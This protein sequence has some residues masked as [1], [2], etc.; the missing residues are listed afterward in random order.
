MADTVKDYLARFTAHLEARDLENAVA[1]AL[2]LLSE[3][4]RDVPELYEGILAP[5]LNRIEVPRAQE[6]A[7][8]WQEHIQ[9]AIVQAVM[10]ASW[11]YVLSQR[12]HSGKPG[13]G[14]RVM[15]AC[16]EEE[17]HEIGIR[18]GADFFRILGFDTAYIG[19]NTPRG[20]LLHAAGTIQP[21]IVV[22]SVTNYLNL[23]Q[24]PATIQAL[25]A[26]KP[27][28]K[29]YLAG[30]ALKHTGKSAADF[31]ADGMLNTFVDVKKL[32]EVAK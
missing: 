8:I 11:P 20:T 21:D 23:A 31:Q 26:A 22:L 13:S 7:R 5:A 32:A 18:M 17:Y 24:L 12:E 25:K 14:R 6:D 15:L 10:G 1:Y 9:S 2:S 29:V 4:K 16:P 27:G 28:L 3:G 19:C 30:S